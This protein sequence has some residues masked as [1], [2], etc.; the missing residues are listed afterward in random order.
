M[1]S[2]SRSAIW[3]WDR[4]V[5]GCH[6]PLL[7]YQISNPALHSHNTLD[8]TNLHSHLPSTHTAAPH[9]YVCFGYKLPVW[10]MPL[11]LASVA[12]KDRAT[13]HIHS[14]HSINTCRHPSPTPLGKAYKRALV[15]PPSSPQKRAFVCGAC[16]GTVQ[17]G[18]LLVSLFDPLFKRSR[19]HCLDICLT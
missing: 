17:V 14:N 9:S 19:L 1:G 13:L 3:A 15:V 7:E 2:W 5:G 6:T 10:H 12:A 11:S 8:A 4:P 18:V 16:T